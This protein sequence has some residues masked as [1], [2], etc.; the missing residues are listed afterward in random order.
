MSKRETT[1]SFCG[2]PRN[3]VGLLIAGLSGHI[4]ESCIAQGYS[5]VQEEFKGL[6]EGGTFKE[7]PLNTWQ[8]AT[9]VQATSGQPFTPAL[10]TNRS[11]SGVLGGQAGIDRPDLV[12]GVKP[13]DVSDA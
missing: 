13:E 10:M 5:I 12:P 3:Q 6:P 8:V 1:C 2:R 9:I 4:C 11:R 7:A